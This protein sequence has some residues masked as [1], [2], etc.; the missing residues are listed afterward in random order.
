MQVEIK[1]DMRV[2]HK[3][4]GEGTVR[5]HVKDPFSNVNPDDLKIATVVFDSL[6]EGYSNPFIVDWEALTPV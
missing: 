6:P 5:K 2:R 1:P 4:F 3:R